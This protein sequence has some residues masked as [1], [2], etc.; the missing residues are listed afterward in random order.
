MSTTTISGEFD[1]KMSPQAQE[2]G[3]DAPGRMLLD[4]RYRGPL[5]ATSIGQML[6]LRTA[7]DGSAGYVA[8]ETVTGTLAG[9]QG[10]FALQHSGTMDRGKPSLSVTVIPDSGTNEL[11]GLSGR[12]AIRIEGGRHFYDFDY[13]LDGMSIA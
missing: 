6:A 2:G 11:R 5:E 10:S 9:R 12:M 7:V 3:A 1:V 8:I 4:K 13:A